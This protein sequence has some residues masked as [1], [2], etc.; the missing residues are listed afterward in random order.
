MQVYLVPVAASRYQL[1]VEVSA[2]PAAAT[3]EAP[4]AGWFARQ[5]QRFQ[6]TLAEAEQRRDASAA[7]RRRTALAR[8]HATHAETIA[9]SD[10]L[11][12][13]H[14]SAAELQHPD[15]LDGEAAVREVRVEFARD[16]AKHL[17]WM[18][19]DGAAVAITGPVF[20]F[21]PGPNLISWYFT[22]RAVGHFFSWRGARKGLTEIQWQ[23]RPT[24]PLTAVRSALLAPQPDRRN[25]L[26]A[27]AQA[28]GLKHFAGFVE[29]VSRWA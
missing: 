13:R 17:R 23:T 28:L 16:V 7:N 22:F 8:H 12:L 21:V 24:A 2:E 19:I 15:D 1:Y 27:I 29:R 25:R 9:S 26:D 14:Q 18:L 11:A 4:D 20:F 3:G 6:Q 5:S 10:C